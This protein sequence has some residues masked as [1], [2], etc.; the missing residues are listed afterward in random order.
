[1]SKSK[2]AVRSKAAKKHPRERPARPRK[3]RPRSAAVGTAKDKKKKSAAAEREEHKKSEARVRA[4]AEAR[5]KKKDGGPGEEAALE[6]TQGEAPEVAVEPAEGE[7][8]ELDAESVAD[9]KEVKALMEQG[10]EKGFL[11][12]EEISDALPS[13]IVASADQIDDV[14]SMFGE[15]DIRIVDNASKVMATPPEPKPVAL[16]EPKHDEEEEKEEEDLEAGYGKSNDPVRMY[17]RKMGSVSLLTREGE[18]EIAKRIEEGEKEILQAVLS[19][20]IAIK[21]ILEMGDRLKKGKVRV[22]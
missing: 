15:H 8:E 1:M 21:E 10:R 12:Y 14:M 22:R 11:T 16:E 9:R 17:L 3:G 6:R 13:D 19:S 2:K 20:S 5:G 18:V 4:A 7:A